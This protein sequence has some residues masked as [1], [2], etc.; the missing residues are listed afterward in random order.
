[1]A[2]VP[3]AEG[4]QPPDECFSLTAAGR[5]L[6]EDLL[7]ERPHPL[8]ELAQAMRDDQ[9]GLPPHSLPWTTVAQASSVS[10]LARYTQILTHEVRNTLLPVQFAAEGLSQR[11]VGTQFEEPTAPQRAAIEVGLRRIFEFVDEWLRVAEQGRPRASFP[12]LAA[13]RDAVAA[14]EPELDR[15]VELRVGEGVATATLVGEREHFTR[16][17]GELLRNALQQAG[18]GVGIVVSVTRGARGLVLDVSDNGP[19]V[20]EADRARIFERGMTTRRDGSGQ[21]LA[22][23]REIVGQMSGSIRV[24]AS[25]EGGARFIVEIADESRGTHEQHR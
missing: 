6:F 10:S 11:L 14:I 1:M 15:G 12:V 8:R 2:G 25:S 22:L 9:E 20:P 21:G 19:G 16:A 13:V 7:A 24:E 18:P 4:T 3:E 5:S 23:V 17:I